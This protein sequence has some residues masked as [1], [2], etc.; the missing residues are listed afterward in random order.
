MS[1]RAYPRNITMLMMF[2]PPPSQQRQPSITGAQRPRNLSIIRR[3]SL[4]SKGLSLTSVDDETMDL[5]LGGV[6]A[7]Q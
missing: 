4:M 6:M 1:P 7:V 5:I 2:P 3:G